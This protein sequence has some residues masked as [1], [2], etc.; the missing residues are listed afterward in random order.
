MEGRKGREVDLKLVLLLSL[1]I[2]GLGIEA[3]RGSHWRA[4]VNLPLLEFYPHTVTGVSW[5][6]ASIDLK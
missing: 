5:A 6:L 2:S 4:L 3:G 1:E